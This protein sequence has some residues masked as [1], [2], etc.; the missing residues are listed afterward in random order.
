[1]ETDGSTWCTRVRAGA[2]RATVAV[3]VAMLVAGVVLAELEP[4]RR[5]TAAATSGFSSTS[6]CRVT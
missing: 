5:V 2:R 4:A 1:M 3:L 6:S